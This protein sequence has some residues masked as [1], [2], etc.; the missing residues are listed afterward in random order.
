M[1]RQCGYSSEEE[2]NELGISSL[3]L[4]VFFA[5]SA[6]P[7]GAISVSALIYRTPLA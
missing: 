4:P 2:E 6:L 7:S 1:I 5:S 3:A